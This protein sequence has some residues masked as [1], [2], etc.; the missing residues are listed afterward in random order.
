MY[1]RRALHLLV[2][3]GHGQAAFFIG[4]HLIGERGDLRVDEHARLG[5]VLGQVHHDQPL[6]HIHL[7]SRQA[8]ARAGV[9]GFEH[10]VDQFA[11]LVIYLFHRLCYRA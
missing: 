5:L 4:C 2:E 1:P 9:H 7:G 11:K 10:V 6:M 8:N 3:A